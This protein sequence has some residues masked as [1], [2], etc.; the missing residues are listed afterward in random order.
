M[1]VLLQKTKKNII[2]SD[3]FKNDRN[4]YMACLPYYESPLYKHRWTSL[5]LCCKALKEVKKSSKEKSSDLQFNNY[6]CS[7]TYYT[8][9]E[10]LI[11]RGSLYIF[12]LKNVSSII[13]NI[14]YTSLYRKYI[15]SKYGKISRVPKA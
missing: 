6:L 2:F 13:H 10:I 5:S 8:F 11:L 7:T 15:I 3:Q 12:W 9:W 1:N 14:I 4:F